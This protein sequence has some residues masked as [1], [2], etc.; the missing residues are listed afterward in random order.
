MVPEARIIILLRDP[1]ER[2]YSHYLMDLREGLQRLSFFEALQ[3]DWQ[4]KR[5]G[6]G[7]S[8]LYVELGLYS[9]QVRRYMRM[10]G[11]SKVKI[12]LFHDLCGTPEKRQS[13]LG[14]IVRFLGVDASYLDQINTSFTENR[15]GVARWN[16][17]RHLA[18][19]NWGR[20]LG[21]IV[22][23]RSIG[24]NHTIKRLIF[25]PFFVKVVA[26]PKIDRSASEWLSA[27]FDPDLQALE[28]LVGRPLPQLRRSWTWREP[29]IQSI[30]KVAV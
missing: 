3:E 22:V 8:R 30:E 29:T 10:F 26:R 20:R 24:S 2:A 14:E 16:W 11:A 15:F 27:I 6:W 12:I 4:R 5:K 18:G 23:P 7:I 25:Q 9:E 28:E 19:S 17:A 1:V 13:A 21:Q